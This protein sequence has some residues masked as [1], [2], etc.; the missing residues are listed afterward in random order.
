MVYYKNVIISLC[1]YL[2]SFVKNHLILKK[3]VMW[4]LLVQMLMNKFII[5]LPVPACFFFPLEPFPFLGFLSVSQVS[6][7]GTVS[8]TQSSVC[9]GVEVSWL[10]DFDA[11]MFENGIL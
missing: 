8:S 4:L 3:S 6:G 10:L 5:K 9:W 11:V 7:S 2:L 1:E